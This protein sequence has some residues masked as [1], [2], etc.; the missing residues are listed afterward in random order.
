[1][2]IRTRPVATRRWLLLAGAVA[3]VGYAW[4]VAAL[5]PFTEP[6]NVLV[7]LPM[8][9]VAVLAAR[10][11]PSS[12]NEQ[13]RLLDT[14]PGARGA[15]VWLALFLAFAAWEVIALFSSPRDDHPTLSS[16]ADWIMSTHAGR[17]AV[18]LAWLAAGAAL[19]FRRPRV[20]GR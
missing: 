13:V 7:A 15:L 8:I 14:A 19:A 3:T 17:A 20:A 4:I 9:P 10:S 6:E 12:P 16:I 2:V 5:R 1:M 18:V 11:R